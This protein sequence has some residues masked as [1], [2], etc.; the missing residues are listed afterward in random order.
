M[1]LVDLP[2][3]PVELASIRAEQSTSQGFD[4][5]VDEVRIIAEL[6]HEADRLGFIDQRYFADSFRGF[7]IPG[8]FDADEIVSYTSI[9]GFQFEGDFRCFS[10][11]H[12][13]RLVGNQAVRAICMT[14]TGAL[15]LPTFERLEETELLHVPVLAVSSITPS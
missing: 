5:L 2:A 14:F 10:K 8:S 9:F 1:S 6:D 13:G 11:V 7:V 15:I 4:M 3:N 12:I